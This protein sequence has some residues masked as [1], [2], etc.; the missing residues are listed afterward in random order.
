MASAAREVWATMPMNIAA[1]VSIDLRTT[2]APRQ[3]FAGPVWP[4]EMLMVL[5]CGDNRRG[6]AGAG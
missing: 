1:T 2:F 4:T 3:P 6:D 5:T